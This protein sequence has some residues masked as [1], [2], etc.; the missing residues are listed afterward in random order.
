MPLEIIEID[1]DW[2]T[3][4]C[5]GQR[6]GAADY[7]AGLPADPGRRGTPHEAYARAYNITY[8][9]SFYWGGVD[10]LLVKEA[11]AGRVDARFIQGAISSRRSL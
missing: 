5:H 9:I 8:N 4:R 1:D 10:K 6:D 11:E 7:D 3:Q 2:N